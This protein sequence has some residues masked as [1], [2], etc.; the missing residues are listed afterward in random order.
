[1]F[2]HCKTY[3]DRI[4]F[5]FIEKSKYESK[6]EYAEE[7]IF[8]RY[9]SLKIEFDKLKSHIETLSKDITEKFNLVIKSNQPKTI[10]DIGN[11]ERFYYFLKAKISSK[12]MLKMHFGNVK[13][14]S[15]SYNRGRV[16]LN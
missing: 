8:L 16:S 9:E 5:S 15:K 10:E 1:M 14:F 11:A 3:S 4:H 6:L 13:L 7:D 12:K 2:K